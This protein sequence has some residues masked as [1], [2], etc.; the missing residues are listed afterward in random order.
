MLQDMGPT[1]CEMRIREIQGFALM[2][3]AFDPKEATMLSWAAVM[4]K[5]TDLL[6]DYEQ[7][8]ALTQDLQ[9]IRNKKITTPHIA[10]AG[11]Y[12]SAGWDLAT[13]NNDLGA[14]IRVLEKHSDLLPSEVKNMSSKKVDKEQAKQAKDY[15]F[16]VVKMMRKK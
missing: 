5:I 7:Y 15:L 14:T 12:Y 16:R 1:A 10:K 4:D 11:M 9:S 2:A 3:K 13:L 8:Q 6:G